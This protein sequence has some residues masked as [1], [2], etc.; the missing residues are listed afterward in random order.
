M[1]KVHRVLVVGVGSI[2]ERHV[3]CFAATGRAQLSICEVNAELRRAVAERYSLEAAFDELES[4][5]AAGPEVV[6]IGTPA[7]LH[8]P[9]A[10]AA[11]QAGTH[12]LTEKPLSTRFDGVT[13]LLCEVEARRIRAGVAYVYRAHPALAAMREAIR[14]GRFGEPVQVVATCGQHFPL[15]RPAY[16]TI[17]YNDRATGGGAVQDALTHVINAAEWLVGPVTRL[18]ADVGHQVLEGVSVEDTAHV[19]TRHGSVMGCFSLNQHQA[20]NETTLTVACARGTARFE[21]HECR[22]RW[23]TEPGAP[24]TDEPFPPLERDALFVR[25]AGAFLDAVEGKAEIL[26]TLAEGRQ[27]LA[28]NLAILRAAERGSWE[29]ITDNP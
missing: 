4:A 1:G 24:W 14:S 18:A 25:Q 17:Y 9:M 12:V 20:P 27:T 11:V 2:G 26:C 7:H 29:T 28:V 8:V 23:A 6:V 3:R 19:L 22:W 13:E 10:R 5:L 21:F 16:R 15:Y